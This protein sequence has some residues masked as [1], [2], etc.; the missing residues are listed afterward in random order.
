MITYSEI[1]ITFNNDLSNE[2]ITFES[3]DFPGGKFETISEAW[4]PV[5]KKGGQVSIGTPTATP[6]ERSAINFIT[7]FNLDYN[8]ILLYTV[9]R[10]VNVVTIKANKTFNDFGDPLISAN[11][12]FVDF[13]INNSVE[14]EYK[15]DSVVFLESLVDASVNVLCSVTTSK[16][17]D[18]ISGTYNIEN[19]GL[20]NPMQFEVPRGSR[21]QLNCELG[22]EVVSQSVKTSDPLHTDVIETELASTPGGSTITVNVESYDLALEYSID[23]INWQSENIF[24][25]I[26]PG[27]YVIYTRDQWNVVA[28]RDIEVP[29]NQLTSPYFYISKSNSIRFKNNIL[30]GDAANYKND[31][32]TLS[33]EVESPIVR[34]EIQRVQ[35]ADVLTTQFKSNYSNPTA[36][37]SQNGVLGAWVPMVKKTENIGRT[38]SR[39]AIVFNLNDG[40]DRTGMIFING[41]IYDYITNAITGTYTL[42]GARPEWGQV[43]NYLKIGTEWYV[44]E[45]V[46]YI[47]ERS[48]EALIFT[49]SVPPAIGVDVD[50]VVKSQYNLFNYEVYEFTI[51]FVSYVDSQ[52]KVHLFNV[53]STWDDLEHISEVIDVKVRQKGTVEIKYWNQHNTDIFYSTGITHKIRILLEKVE[54]RM[55]DQTETY[56]TDSSAELITSLIHEM[57]LFE[58]RPQTKEMMRKIIQA[59]SHTD[60]FLDSVKYVKDSIEDPE[61][62]GETNTY[63]I[64][65]LMIKAQNVYDSD[66]GA[67]ESNEGSSEIPA[68]IPTGTGYVKYQ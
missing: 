50:V 12:S 34:R 7:S 20:D 15:I 61:P 11:P 66:S 19:T 42:N 53:S 5:R 4:V 28:Q 52:V 6:G 58:F 44:I 48:A 33:C 29:I 35:T 1:Q 38:D 37:I 22:S 51:D 60:V 14:V 10:S 39:D 43:G 47:E 57:D 41:N 56:E 54:G 46:L 25:S 59:L 24:T 9:E 68:L 64:G 17:S 3:G 62:V 49:Q 36:R 45:D 27:S 2:I 16:V 32:N 8:E 23:N 30:W 40:T 67:F 13:V 31:E 63:I 55:K 18:R 21:F 65:A 26:A